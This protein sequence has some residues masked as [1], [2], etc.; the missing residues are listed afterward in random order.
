MTYSVLTNGVVNDYPYYF[1]VNGLKVSI[2]DISLDKDVYSPQDYVGGSVT[3]DFNQAINGSVQLLQMDS[4]GSTISLFG[5]N[6]TFSEGPNTLYIDSTLNASSPGT[7]MLIFN[8]Y[9]GN[10]TDPVCSSSKVISVTGDSIADF[11]TDS[12]TY[13][14]NETI[15]TETDISGTFPGQL[16]FI[17]NGTTVASQPFK[18][19][20]GGY[21]AVDL[22]LTAGNREGTV[23]L[24]VT[25]TADGQSDSV[26]TMLSIQEASTVPPPVVSPSLT[27]KL[28]IVPALTSEGS[29]TLVVEVTSGGAPV[30]GAYVSLDV[31]DGELSEYEGTTSVNGNLNV[32]YTAPVLGEFDQVFLEASADASGYESAY[33]SGEPMAAGTLVNTVQVGAAALNISTYSDSQILNLSFNQQSRTISFN[34]TGDPSQEGSATSPSRTAP[35]RALHRPEGWRSDS[36]C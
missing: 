4:S 1:D 27:A 9:A 6:V 22:S 28:K 3:V 16:Q 30:S 21:T 36:G 20:P 23:P 14:F 7:C 35:K 8:V 31:S 12:T 33:V 15:Q 19:D 11:W 17:L 29:C 10:L 2:S 25:L 13:G 5:E 34:V 24:T 32:T 18:P 26:S